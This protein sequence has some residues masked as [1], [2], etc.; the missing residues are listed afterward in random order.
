MPSKEFR[1]DNESDSGKRLDVYISQFISELSRSQ[2]QKLIQQGKVLINSKPVEKSSYK[3]RY[4][5]HIRVTYRFSGPMEITPE[6]I[7]LDIVYQDKN[8]VVI[9]KPSGLVVHPGAGSQRSTLVNA[10]LYHFPEIK[11]IGPPN[12]PG[13]VHRLDKETSGLIVVAQDKE[14]LSSLKDQFKK[15]RIGKRYLTLVWGL[16]SKKNGTISWPIGR[17]VKNGARMSVRTQK[18]KKAETRFSVLRSFKEH[19][20]LDVTPL[21]GRTHQIRVHMAASGHPIVGDKRYGKRKT[22][23]H[24]ESRLFLHAYYLSFIHPETRERVEF[25][26]PLPMDLQH[27]LERI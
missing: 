8:I 6:N 16:Y 23:S 11:N 3:I 4:G 20:L 14:A 15:R 2:I 18:P 21:T 25:T 17:H 22:K 10:L 5:D 13:I 27:I 9:N 26:I 7:T 19:S 12:R 1:I 24:I